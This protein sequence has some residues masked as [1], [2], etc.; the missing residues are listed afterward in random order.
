M[1]Y[2]SGKEVDMLHKMTP[3]KVKIKPYNSPPLDIHGEVRCAVT[4]GK[5][6]VPVVWH[7]ISGSHEPIL[8]GNAALQL[9]IIKFTNSPD[10]FEPILMISQKEKIQEQT[11]L[12][13]YPGNFNGIGRLRN[14]QVN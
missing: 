11:I 7:V 9:G 4:S 5:S 12:Q 2:N 10:T 14:H 8:S 3:S 13:R 6:S 1:W